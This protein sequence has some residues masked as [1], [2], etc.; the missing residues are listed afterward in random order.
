[1]K[2]YSADKFRDCSILKNLKKQRPF[3]LFD[4]N[5]SENGANCLAKILFY[6]EWISINPKNSWSSL[7]SHS[8]SRKFYHPLNAVLSH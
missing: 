8:D 4:E 2:D 3:A 1:M 6:S 7:E 5:L